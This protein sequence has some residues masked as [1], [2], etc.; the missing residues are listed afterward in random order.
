ML[1]ATPT[2]LVT[3]GLVLALPARAASQDPP[4][5]VEV[6]SPNEEVAGFS[7]TAAPPPIELGGYLDIG[8]ADAEGDGTSFH[9]DDRRLPVDYAV[10]AFAPAVNA[11]G[12]AASTE[13]GGRFTNGFLP[14]S[15]GIAGRPSFL[16]NTASLDLRHGQPTGTLLLF[17]RVQLVPRLHERGSVARVVLEQAYGRVAPFAS[18]ELFLHAGKFDSVFGIEYLEKEAPQ[19]VGITPSLFARYTTGAYIGGKLFYRFQLAPLWSA[20]SLNLAITN[21]APFSEVLLASE[22]SLTGRPVLTG[23]LGYELNLP[24][25]QTRLGLS[26]LRGPRND[27]GD[28]DA[29]QRAQALDLRIAFFGLSLSGELLDLEQDAGPAADKITGA[30]RQLIPS[31]FGAEGFWTQLAYALPFTRDLL[32]RVT[33]HGRFEQRRARFRGFAPVEVRR[34]TAGVRLDLGDSVVLKGE[35]LLNRE[36]AGAPDVDN[37]VRTASLVWTF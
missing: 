20:L 37:D 21:S 23:R 25:F 31:G 7:P 8:F 29:R 16:L 6:A 28:P 13:T 36:L 11:R 1:R 10:D 18:Q 24:G 35:V 2:L 3:A 30:G 33:L 17:A 34:V 19:R 14:R 22:V 12:D 4:D 5:E 9:P 32:R 15:A 26:V 27:Q